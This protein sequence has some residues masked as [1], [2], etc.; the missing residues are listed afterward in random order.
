MLTLELYSLMPHFLNPF[1]TGVSKTFVQFIFSSHRFYIDMLDEVIFGNFEY[2]IHPGS[3][4][5]FRIHRGPR[6]H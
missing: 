3:L 1:C 5:I 6:T 2:V 4:E